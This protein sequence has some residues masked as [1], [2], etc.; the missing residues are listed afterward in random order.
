M[1]SAE[2]ASAPKNIQE[3][4]SSKLLIT[5]NIFFLLATISYIAAAGLDYIENQKEKEEKGVSPSWVATCL[6]AL[7]FV[8]VGCVDFYNTQ[9]AIHVFL[10]LAG[11]FGVIAAAA[12]DSNPKAS[13]ACNLLSAH[14]FLV[15]S[16][17]WIWGHCMRT[18]LDKNDSRQYS[19]MTAE[20][21]DFL[22]FLGALIDVFLSYFYLSNNKD[23][24]AAV[25]AQNSATSK[26]EV[27]SAVLWFFA[28][29]LTTFVSCRV[30]KQGFSGSPPA[31]FESTTGGSMT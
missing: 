7:G 1:A 9:K 31:T 3:Y 11:I 20:L 12:S 17:Q 4:S 25:D 13:L 10:I 28:A 27:T 30:G 26:A 14:L 21:G 8:V 19:L 22:F 2:I 6:G 29:V 5:S 16:V 23:T 24:G 18:K 15:E